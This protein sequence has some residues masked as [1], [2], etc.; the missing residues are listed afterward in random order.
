MTQKGLL[1]EKGSNEI[2]GITVFFSL[3]DPAAEYWIDKLGM[4]PMELGGLLAPTS[5]SDDRALKAALPERF[6]GDRGLYSA[7]YFM[8][9]QNEVLALHTL[10]QDELWFFHLGCAV[11]LHV[12]D[13]I[14]RTYSVVTV[15]GDFDKGE[16]L[17]AVAPHNQWFGAELVSPGY[18]LVSCSLA[19][20]F[21][22]RDSR[23]PTAEQLAELKRMFPRQ[24]AILDRLTGVTPAR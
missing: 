6:D 7:N 18:A 1:R 5:V 15:G 2:I 23:R 9:R 24:E 19:P 22:P 11:R 16:R 14:E 13:P 17:Q 8:L 12:F 3:E 20:G 10:N 4:T 21:D